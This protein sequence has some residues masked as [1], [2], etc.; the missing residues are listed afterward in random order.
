M[1]KQ[2]TIL[3]G[4]WKAFSE[5]RGLTNKEEPE[6]FG[7]MSAEEA[8]WYEDA[9]AAIDATPGAREFLRSLKPEDSSRG[10]IV[11]ALLDK[12]SSSHS[13][14]SMCSLIGAYRG[15]LRDWDAW[16]STT[17]REKLLREYKQKQIDLTSLNIFRNHLVYIGTPVS[18][19]EGFK[20][21][22]E[23]ARV[24]FSDGEKPVEVTWDDGAALRSVATLI[25][26]L[27]V[28]REEEQAKWAA[29]RFKERIEHLEFNL[30]AACRW[31]W[32]G[33]Q[34]PRYSIS[35]EEMAEMERL[36]PG[37]RAHIDLVC[38]HINHMGYRA[39][40]AQSPENNVALIKRLKELGIMA[41]SN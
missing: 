11:D 35:P 20:R 24:S 21:A 5:A 6:T 22:M 4:G 36:H 12:M 23:K 7:W 31:F 17:K 8:F 33:E 27:R 37:Y 1:E 15:A 14:A 18:N 32:P 28:M 29:W 19:D 41:A 10:S 30:K 34:H 26:E 39:S 2:S 38:D 13:G 3:I 16:V 9:R 25:D 40:W